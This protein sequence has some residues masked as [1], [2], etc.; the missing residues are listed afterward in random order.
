MLTA[1]RFNEIASQEADLNH[2]WATE[3]R[4]PLIQTL[5]PTLKYEV[6]LLTPP[7]NPNPILTYNDV[8]NPTHEEA[9]LIADY[10]NYRRSYYNDGYAQQ[11]LKHPL[12]VDSTTNTVILAK[13]PYSWVYRRTSW[14]YG[15]STVPIET[16]ETLYPNLADLLDHINSWAGNPNPAYENWKLNRTIPTLS[17]I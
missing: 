8:Q 3:G 16:A 15:P 13:L 10:I 17:K 1:E 9:E 14:Q 6:A 12:D 5:H 11:M 7:K 4:I 2:P